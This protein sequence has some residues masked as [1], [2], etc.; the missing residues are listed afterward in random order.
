MYVLIGLLCCRV[1]NLLDHESTTQN[2]GRFV[3]V[4]VFIAGLVSHCVILEGEICAW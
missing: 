1:H 4:M 3:D 2:Y